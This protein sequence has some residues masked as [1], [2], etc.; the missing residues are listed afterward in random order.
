MFLQYAAPGAVVPQLTLQLDRL[1]FTPA[2]AG[3]VCATQALAALVGPL[4]AGQIADRWWPAERCLVVCGLLASALLWALAEATSPGTVFGLSLGFWLFMGS[5]T[6]LGTAISFARLPTPERDFGRIRLWGT[7][8]WVA[9]SFALGYWYADPPWLCRCVGWLRPDAPYSQPA[10]VFRLASGL[11]LALAV[12]ALTLRPLPAAPRRGPAF[13]PAAALGLLRHRGFAIYAACSLGV[14][15]TMAFNYQGTQLLLTRLG[16]PPPWVSPAQ[17]LG[18]ATEVLTLALLPVLLLRL[19]TRGT[20]LLGLL[21]Q[22]G[23][24]ALLTLGA[25]LGLVLLA[26]C[27]WGVMVCGYLVAG[28]VFVNGLAQG[29]IRASAQALLAFTNAVGLLIGNLLAGWVRGRAGGELM[30][31]FALA[32]VIAAGLVAAFG[33][34]FPTNAA[35]AVKEK[36]GD[37]PHRTTGEQMKE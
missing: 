26:L 8:G 3:W 1:H 19:G 24:F 32:M 23:S 13:A 29:D 18:Q 12:Y 37:L 25:P 28:Q 30:P 6:T 9:A 17:T 10:D 31:M 11:A 15:L 21:V 2:Q 5:A 33:F 36:A 34:G 22:T 14:C 20:M 4:L 27:G 35:G 16:V 7:V